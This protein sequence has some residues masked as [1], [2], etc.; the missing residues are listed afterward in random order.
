MRAPYIWNTWIQVDRVNMLSLKVKP[1]SVSAV[2]TRATVGHR[3]L[4]PTCRPSGMWGT[5]AIVSC[6]IMIAHN[7]TPLNICMYVYVTTTV[8]VN[9][10]TY[11]NSLFST[12]TNLNA[13]FLIVKLR[14]LAV[15][16]R[17]YLQRP[18]PIC[19]P[20]SSVISVDICSR[21]DGCCTEICCCISYH[22]AGQN[23]ELLT[24]CLK[25]AVSVNRP[26]ESHTNAI[27]K[28]KTV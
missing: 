9:K 7:D 13:E 8:I 21:F 10:F 19:R 4:W 12:C 20:F 22:K 14:I 26:K 24:Q 25:I 1:V 18:T 27:Y 15:E 6:M 11:R 3:P 17:I 23:Y 5:A 28:Y 2:P 16:I